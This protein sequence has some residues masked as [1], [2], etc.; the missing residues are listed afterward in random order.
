MW[1]RTVRRSPDALR[2]GERARCVVGRR[3]GPSSLRL[4]LSVWFFLCLVVMWLAQ[5]ADPTPIRGHAPDCLSLLPD[6]RQLLFFATKSGWNALI[7]IFKCGRRVRHTCAGSSLKPTK[8]AIL[9]DRRPSI[10]ARQQLDGAAV[11]P[12]ES[13][14]NWFG[15]RGSSRTSAQL[16]I[17][18]MKL[19]RRGQ[20]QTLRV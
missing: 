5:T 19:I 4:R 8:G 6:G 17:V 7:G 10:S 11:R 18:Y 2:R 20:W 3:A 13:T 1:K 9:R 15:D 12:G 14:N 16:P